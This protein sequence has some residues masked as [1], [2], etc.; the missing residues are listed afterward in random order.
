MRK[1]RIYSLANMASGTRHDY[2]DKVFCYTPKK[3]EIPLRMWLLSPEAEA[4]ISLDDQ[5]FLPQAVLSTQ[6]G[7]A[8]DYGRFLN[9]IGRFGQLR[10]R[11]LSESALRTSHLILTDRLDWAPS[12]TLEETQRSLWGLS[13]KDAGVSMLTPSRVTVGEAVTFRVAYR[14]AV[15]LPAGSHIRFGI[16]VA[17][18]KPQTEDPQKAGYLSVIGGF[19]EVTPLEPERVV[20]GHE[21]IFAV[22]ELTAPLTPADLLEVAYHTDHVFLFPQT[23]DENEME[24]WYTRTPVMN[25]SVALPGREDYVFLQN[26]NAHSL[27]ICPDRPA[28]LHLFLPGRLHQGESILLRGLFT[29]RY[30]NPCPKTRPNFRFSLHLQ[31]NDEPMEALSEAPVY[32]SFTRFHASLSLR[33]PGIYRVIA[34][35]ENGTK[36]AESNP[37]QLLPA[38]DPLPNVYWGE[39]HAHCGMSDGIGEY[40]D[41]FAFGRD[42]SALDFAASADH[43][44]YFSD[45]EWEAMQDI[46][47]SFNSDGKYT[48]LVA[49]E[50][51]GKQVHRNIYT[52][53]DRLELFR[54]M[55]EPTSNLNTVYDHFHG[56]EDVVAGPHGSI[57]HG[58]EF[59]HHDP[60]VE[61]FIEI[62]SMWGAQDRPDGEHP[63]VRIKPRSVSV[64]DLLQRGAHLGFTG[65]G[66]CHEGHPGFSSCDPERQGKIPHAAFPSL[67]YRCGLTASCMESLNRKNLIDAL[68]NRHTYATTG[69]RILADFTLCDAPMGEI[70]KKP[71]GERLLRC[72]YHLTAPGDKLQVIRNGELRWEETLS[73]RDGCFV[74]T[75]FQDN[76]STGEDVYYIKILQRDGQVLWTSPIW[77]QRQATPI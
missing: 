76:E 45:N 72:D 53:R 65:G 30:H 26:A 24:Y 10:I 34:V 55:Y 2:F 9:P 69:A 60:D 5:H 62:Y 52:Y 70:L 71:A 38:A 49:F 68:R 57:A 35:D 73:C 63:P 12:S 39:I 47:N 44:C 54:G 22:Y 48:T 32:D 75:D 20:E 3:E 56:R 14:P 13:R 29:D 21:R 25:V 17:F 4:E 1:S 6:E 8:V 37:F 40:A 42:I 36:I 19:Q 43:A 41:L 50:W 18:S 11:R 64:N 77:I 31:Y 59:D 33:R 16:P 58:I 46:C 15:T 27:T 23:Y 66:D 28:K 67:R 51:A 74:W 61:R 7:Y